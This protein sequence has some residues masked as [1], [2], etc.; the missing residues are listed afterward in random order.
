MNMDKEL[1][2]R[3]RIDILCDEDSFCEMFADFYTVA[4]DFPNYA[5]KLRVAIRCSNEREAVVCGTCT[6]M[7]QKC[8][9]FVMETQFMMGSMG[10]VVGEKITRC[11]EFATEQR[12]PVVGVCASGGVRVQE[13]LLSL[14]QMAK[15]MGALQKHGDNGNLFISLLTNPTLGGVAASFAMNGDIILAEP[16][17]TVGLSG[18]RIVENV[19]GKELPSDF[20]KVEG[21]LES[22]YIDYIVER[23][24]QRERIGSLLKLHENS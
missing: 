17:I 2:A 1:R 9:I 16:G 10:R 21:I 14:M 13:G 19:E 8:I 12:L 22:G 4:N 7:G 15:V 5:D 18:K 20:Q 3:N 23:Q 6:I 24:E 11:F